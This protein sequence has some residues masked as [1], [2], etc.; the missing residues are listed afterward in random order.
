M[1]VKS[2]DEPQSNASNVVSSEPSVAEP[3]TTPVVDQTE[4]TQIDPTPAPKPTPAPA[5]DQKC[6]N[7]KVAA[8]APL[9]AKID[10][11]NAIAKAHRDGWNAGR[12]TNLTDAQLDAMIE[13]KFGPV[14]RLNQQN[15]DAEAAKFNC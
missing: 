8:L 6:L 14:F 7:D 13:M 4:Q 15:Y 12:G 9:Q 11:T 5:V 1:A 10:E 2:A 3:Q